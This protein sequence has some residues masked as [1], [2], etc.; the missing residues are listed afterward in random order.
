M[1]LPVLWASSVG[2][3]MTS[4]RSTPP[5]TSRPA[6]LGLFPPVPPHSQLVSPSRGEPQGRDPSLL[7]CFAQQGL[8]LCSDSLAF[9]W[10][11]LDWLLTFSF[12]STYKRKKMD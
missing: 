1:T 10:I 5:A 12:P 11:L 2:S 8:S 4:R 6:M 3:T 9:S 7:S